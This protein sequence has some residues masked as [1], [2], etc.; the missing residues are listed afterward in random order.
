MIALTANSKIDMKN[1]ISSEQL[2][3]VLEKPLMKRDIETIL[4]NYGRNLK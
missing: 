3:D 4:K 1:K 2:D